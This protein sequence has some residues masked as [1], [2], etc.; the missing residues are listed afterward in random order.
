[1]S[2]FTFVPT[3]GTGHVATPKS[4]SY[5]RESDGAPAD[6]LAAADYP[7]TAVCARCDGP[8]RLAHPLQ[9]EWRHAPA[10]AAAAGGAP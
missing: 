5:V 6:L 9:W 3:D 10:V 4:G 7:I 2:G 8:I 1:V